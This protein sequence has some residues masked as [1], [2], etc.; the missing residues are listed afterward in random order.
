M[1]PLVVSTHASLAGRDGTRRRMATLPVRFL[2]TRPLRDATIMWKIQA[3][4]AAFLPTR[5]LRDA[6][7]YDGV[8]QQA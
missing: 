6:T 5:P 3:R 2:P 1:T 7:I 4:Q 8:E